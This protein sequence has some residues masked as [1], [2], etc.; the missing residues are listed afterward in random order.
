VDRDRRPAVSSRCTSGARQPGPNFPA[1]DRTIRSSGLR[2]PWATERF[3]AAG[4]LARAPTPSRLD[5]LQSQVLVPVEL[6]LLNR[7]QTE[8]LGAE[9]V[10]AA[11]VEALDAH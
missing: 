2:A 10:L 8:S 7:S 4:V 5:E 6:A 11:A 3:V 9:Q 1:G